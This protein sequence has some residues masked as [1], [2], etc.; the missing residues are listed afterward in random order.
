MRQPSAS[1]SWGVTPALVGQSTVGY[2]EDG[3]AAAATVAAYL[4]WERVARRGLKIAECS[5]VV[6]RR[7]TKPCPVWGCV[8]NRITPERT[9]AC[10]I[11]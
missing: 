9:P 7:A 1:A 4:S 6:R 3:S 8:A 5:S 11:H 10:A 2:V